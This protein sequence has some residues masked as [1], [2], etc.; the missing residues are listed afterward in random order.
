M[1]IK[2]FIVGC[3]MQKLLIYLF[4]TY[5]I[6][7][8]ITNANEARLLRFPNTSSKEIAFCYAGDIYTVPI[9]GGLAKRITSSDGE[10]LFPRFSPDGKTIAFSGEYDGNR[11]VYIIPSIGGTPKR[12]TYS[13]DIPD[14]PER[15]GPDKITMQWTSDGKKILYRARQDQWNAFIGALY[16]VSIDG[17]LPEQLP[18]PRG[19]FA[20]FSPDGN[21]L[22]YNRI[23][24]EFRTW[25]RY[26]GGMADDIWIY[27]FKT[28]KIENITNNDA[29]DIIPMWYKNKIYY[30]SDRDNIMNLY[31]YDIDTKNTRK[32][33]NFTEF[34]IKFPSLGTNHIAFEKG[35]YIYLMDLNTEEISKVNIR[36]Q[37]D[38]P[39]SRPQI[40]NVSGSINQFEI[41]PDGKRALLTARGDI[42]TVP[43]EKGKIR[44]I[45]RSPGVHD[46]SA[47]WSPDGKWIAYISD[48][49]GEDEVFI[50][51]SDGSDHIQITNGTKSYRYQLKWSPDSKKLLCSDKLM[52]LTIIDIT[53]KQ[54]KVI[55]TS[56]V[57]EI[58]D[59]IWSP[60]SKW[61]AYTDYKENE[62]A[63]IYLYSLENS[64]TYQITDE[65]FNSFS[66]VFDPGS[67][68]LFFVSNRTFK[69][70]LGQFERSYV[71]NEMSKIY[72]LTLT[73][74]IKTPF[75]FESDEVTIKE[76][77]P[78][79]KTKQ[80]KKDNKQEDTGLKIQI[81]GLK[82]RIF[83]LPVQ[84]G[85]YSN[86]KMVN[87]SKLYYVRSASGQ[88]P[89]LYA[90]DFDKK[91]EITV[92]DFSAYEI[93]TDGKK[94]LFNIG[95]DYYIEK[96]DENVKPGTGK[97]DLSEMKIMLD[98]REEWQQIFNESW[99]QMRDFL[100]APNLHGVNWVEIKRKYEPL[101]PHV[102]HRSDL[103]YIIGEMIGEL[104]VGHA[105]VGGGEKPVVNKIPIGLLGAKFQLDDKSGFY[106]I[107][108][109]Y[110]G[111]NWDESTRSPL[112]EPGINIKVGDYLL[113]IDGETLT[114]DIHP[115]MQ[116]VDKANKYV[117]LTVNSR[118]N[119]TG[120]REVTVKTIA[121]EKGLIYYN[122]VERNRR[123]V[124]SV[125]GG[126]VAYVHIPN[127]MF[128]GLN[129]FVKYFYPQTRKEAL[130]V[131]DRFNGGGFVSQMILERLRRELTMV[132]LARNQ[133][134]MGTY[135]DGVFM[136]PMVCLLNEFSASDGDIFPYNFKKNNLGKL[137]GKRSWGGVIGIRGSLPILDGG[138]LNRPEFS[139]FSVEG[140]WILEGVGMEPDII[141][142][143]HPGKEFEGIDEQLD[144]AIQVV[145]E[146]LKTDTRP[147]LPKKI[148]DFPIRR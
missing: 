105:Y 26:R 85:N 145:L 87:K 8:Q 120:S 126:K 107:I 130:I 61:V 34:D 97:L 25:K 93:S 30:L 142:D 137:I 21:K 17:G 79:N 15:M 58:T 11:E 73:D 38:F 81:D 6:S 82:D 147:K 138:Y 46:R 20:S 96:L 63:V 109:I 42:F 111:R 51:K 40:I 50:A 102:N 88:K 39:W 124:D 28:K 69:P 125:S 74:T 127:M 139:H 119:F 110:E 132:A 104:N 84:A 103:T 65:F 64:N 62:F 129:E 92:G 59:F 98:R 36:L 41:S 66:P 99:R 14:V 148:P 67:R 24:R 45:T 32:I 53:T 113:A 52:R 4:F 112:T 122:W 2:Y 44:N 91:K 114:K 141:V 3:K 56:D 143:N 106:R 115:Y 72:G 10:E 90:Y 140:E 31:V 22:A 80:S 136:G 5:I 55:T 135:P 1:F 60:D 54:E 116:L 77:E 19:G 70:Q 29:Q 123:Y 57:W 71:Y 131:D 7:I 78:Q 9:E 100:Y 133:K 27:D 108:H 144:K 76:D 134:V 48:R 35:G 101:V 83:E 16:L 118:P 146:E 37:G 121:S 47:V 128:E 18:L 49:T 86:L 43:A 13:M 23:F 94:I 117:T 75:E 12:L 89:A 68:Y 33:T 95:K